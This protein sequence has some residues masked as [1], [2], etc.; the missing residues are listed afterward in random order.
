MNY[1]SGFIVGVASVAAFLGFMFLLI[2]YCPAPPKV[3]PLFVLGLFTGIL[4]AFTVLWA[5]FSPDKI[6]LT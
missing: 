3:D 4:V 5:L 1:A 6:R 2:R